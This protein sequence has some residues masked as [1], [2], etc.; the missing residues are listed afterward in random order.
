M[1]SPILATGVLLLAHHRL[2]TFVRAME[3]K[4]AFSS[5]ADGGRRRLVEP[6][7]DFER[8]HAGN[9]ASV[10]VNDVE[11]KVAAL[12]EAALSM[13]EGDVPVPV[14][15]RSRLGDGIS[16][17]AVAGT[18]AL[19][20]GAL[21]SAFEPK[22]R[23]LTEVIRRGTP[24]LHR[25]KLLVPST[26][27]VLAL[28]KRSLDAST[29]ED[30]RAFCRAYSTGALCALAADVVINPVLRGVQARETRR[31]W[32]RLGSAGRAAAEAL[33][34]E[35]LLE[36]TGGSAWTDWWPAVSDIPDAV[37]DG[38]IA[39]IEEVHHVGS[40]APVG[41]TPN[42]G[43]LAMPVR[44][45]LRDAYQVFFRGELLMGQNL[46]FGEWFGLMLPV[47]VAPLIALPIAAAHDRARLIFTPST[48]TTPALQPDATSW[49][50]L[51]SL[52]GLCGSLTPLIYG[53]VVKSQFRGSDWMIGEIIGMAVGR[54]L[55]GG[56][57][58]AAGTD[59]GLGAAMLVLQLIPD[60]IAIVQAIAHYA[61][62]QPGA[63]FVM[64]TQIIPA[65]GAILALLA[66]A[67]FRGAGVVWE[68]GS[69]LPGWLIVLLI[70]IVLA[71][72][73]AGIFKAIGGFRTFALTGATPNVSSLDALPGGAVAE[74]RALAHLFDPSS[75]W[76]D[77]AVA[78][79]TADFRHLH[80]PAGARDLV[81]IWWSG[82][83]DVRLTHDDARLQFRRAS[84]PPADVAIPPGITATAL[85]E[86]IQ[87]TVNTAFGGTDLHAVAAQPTAI[88]ATLPFPRVVEDPG[89]LLA[90]LAEHAAHA[91][92]ETA[93]GTSEGAATVLRQAH[94]VDQ[95]TTFG[96]VGPSRSSVEGWKVVPS[97]ARGDADV[98][99]LGLAADLAALLC[100][101]A[102]PELAS[103]KPRF[104]G[105]DM[106][107]IHQVFR[108]WNLDERSVN[109]WRTLVAGAAQPERRNGAE[110]EDD[111]ARAPATG[112]SY[113]APT[114]TD[115]TL[116]EM[117]WI[118]AW[119]AWSRVAGDI[120][121]NTEAPSASPY[122]PPR[123]GPEGTTS[124]PS[125]A[126]LSAAI[127]YLLDL[128]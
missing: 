84:G 6:A 117:G 45:D 97:A 119:R 94:R 102:A 78:A 85:A 76:R 110:G 55:F 4:G 16:R 3:A 38:W 60:L 83:G 88:A 75:M 115:E 100:M 69:F 50:A 87:T 26:D 33:V 32:D 52:G 70:V 103:T 112:S 105:A 5:V 126:Q 57:G 121:A 41:L 18:T 106:A 80:Y 53:L 54:A 21:V 108:K 104:G 128:G 65:I 43:P 101:G 120:T 40:T 11:R 9:R 58:L 96:S 99:A 125:N 42:A 19:E 27:L 64:L 82:S 93:L 123:P 118:P 109:E 77:P 62:N 124:P 35:R 17:G 24:D 20:L 95:T 74:P 14:P 98:T 29:T 59:G 79:A 13:I 34:V 1:S 22:Y 86:R 2:K 12:A 36:R 37:L 61:S 56:I 81:K 10:V 66:G 113:V 28:A 51:T 15:A 73:F 23:W 68:P 90:T 92:D 49:L 63:G 89:D 8:D 44:A 30:Q 122:T 48:T 47:F 31:D 107:P 114:S 25:S 127:R 111:G 46:G 116:L 67:A 72:I 7:T 91:A 71:L 39:A